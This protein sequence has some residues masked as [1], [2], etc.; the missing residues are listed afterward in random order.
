MAKVYMFPEK[1]KLPANM[2]KRVKEMA[3]EYMEVVY[4]IMVLLGVEDTD[5]SDY[6]EVMELIAEA[7]GE[8]VADAIDEFEEL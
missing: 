8:G 5:N 2:E 4:A 7:F 3:K 1:K 6:M